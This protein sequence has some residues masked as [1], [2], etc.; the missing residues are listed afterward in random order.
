MSTSVSDN[1]SYPQACKLAANYDIYFD[2]FK[3][4]PDYTFVLEHVT[5]EEGLEYYKY[6]PQ[7]IK[8]NISKFSVNDKFGSPKMWN[9][10]FGEFS[11]TTLR[12]AKILG[13]LSQLK[14]D[15]SKIVEVGCGYGGQYT[16]LRQMFKPEKY[17][18]I[19]LKEP[20]LL[21]EKYVKMHRLDDIKLEFLSPDNIKP[22]ESDIFISN[23]AISECVT[24][25]QDMYIENFV[26]RAKHGYIIH[27]N[28]TG[29]SHEQFIAKTNKK[30][31]VFEERPKLHDKNVLLVW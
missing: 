23:Y 30:I 15:G 6:S 4:N 24:D 3:S 31:K 22:V 28:F 18:F 29:Y 17:T 25:V 12:Y 16:V 27:N 21:I 7:H 9:Y 10:A 20:L 14:L 19:D 11:P 13:D 5:Y 2:K 26:N 8:D 1:E